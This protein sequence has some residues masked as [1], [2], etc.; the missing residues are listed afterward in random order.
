MSIHH[1]HSA[2]CSQVCPPT[3]DYIDHEVAK[4][5]ATGRGSNSTTKGSSSEYCYVSSVPLNRTPHRAE[6]ATTGNI[7]NVLYND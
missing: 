1:T 7:Y 6:P 3:Y 2:H 5:S 4:G